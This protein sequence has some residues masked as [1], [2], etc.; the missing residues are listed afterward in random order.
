ME[1]FHIFIITGIFAGLSAGLFGLGGGLVTVPALLLVFNW[2][3]FSADDKV[4]M[5]L[6][7]SL[8]VIC[9]TALSSSITHWRQGHVELSALL[10]LTPGLI[11]GAFLGA[12]LVSVTP[13]QW[14]LIVFAGFML[15]V[16][17]KMWRGSKVA[18]QANP[19]ARF[20]WPWG[21]AIGSISA[22]FGIGGGTFTVPLMQRKAYG[23]SQAIG[24]SAACALPIA[25]A[26]TL[27][28]VL[29]GR[30][31]GFSS[32]GYVYG[33]AFVGLL[34]TSPLFAYIGAR[35]VSRLDKTLLRK[36][37]AVLLLLVAARMLWFAIGD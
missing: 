2:L 4:P 33:P 13:G 27:A 9:F 1:F 34:I 36:L 18:V 25:W 8:A 37:F 16:A 22:L 15:W 10:Q 21:F 11:V 14:L 12:L 6:A 28:F 31:Q 30:Q 5:A 24:T 32:L 35:L 17:Q 29:L 3:G 26:G 19:S 7:T 23:I 20:L